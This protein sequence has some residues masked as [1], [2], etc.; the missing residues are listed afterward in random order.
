MTARGHLLVRRTTAALPGAPGPRRSHEAGAGTA[1]ASTPPEFRSSG[2]EGGGGGGPRSQ[3]PIAGSPAS[4]QVAMGRPVHLLGRP[5]SWRNG[6]ASDSRSEGCVFKSRR[7]QLLFAEASIT[8]IYSPP[9][10]DSLPRSPSAQAEAA[11]RGGR[12][13]RAPGAQSRAAPSGEPRSRGL[14]RADPGTQSLGAWPGSG[15]RAR[16]AGPSVRRAGE[17]VVRLAVAL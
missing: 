11:P 1:Q 4:R 8:F 2:Q 10:R 7:G 16:A 9:R 17:K 5:T 3:S 14:V 13:R 6:S 12:E 15:G